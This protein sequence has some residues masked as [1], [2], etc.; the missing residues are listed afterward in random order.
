[1][2]QPHVITTNT[3]LRDTAEAK[4]CA[5]LLELKTAVYDHLAADHALSNLRFPG[6]LDHP[7]LAEW[8]HLAATAARAR[9]A[10]NLAADLVSIYTNIDADAL[11]SA[12]E[13]AFDF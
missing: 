13:A 2:Q 10:V 11:V 9:H 1:M 3:S 6:G 4:C 8:Q 5:L 12:A 7:M